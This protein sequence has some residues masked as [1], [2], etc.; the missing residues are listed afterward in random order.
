MGI[1]GLT[2]VSIGGLG[3]SGATLAYL[4]AR[5]GFRVEAFDVA[6]GYRKACG[7]A[8]TL[9]PF[10]E[11]I[12]RAT[13]S[14]VTL[15]TR[16][17][18]AVNGEVVQDLSLKPPPWAIVDKALLVS[19][20]REMAEAEGAELKAGSWPGPVGG[21]LSVDA[22]GPL[23]DTVKDAVFLYRVYSKAEWE[24]DTVYLDFNV[25]DRGVYWV[26]PA[27]GEGRLVNIGAGFEGVWSGRE[28]EMR[29][30]RLHKTL[31]GSTLEPVDRRG[32]P[33]QL[34]APLRLYHEGVFKVGEAGGFLLRTGGEG[35]RPGMLSALHLARAI[36]SAGL[37]DESKILA[38]YR[39]YSAGLAD[40]VR[41]SKILLSIVRG[42]SIREA[43]R[44]LKSL[45]PSFWERFVRAQVTSTYLIR[46]L[47]HPSVAFGVARALLSY[48]ASRA[49]PQA[50]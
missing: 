31:L 15:V 49:P 27:D 13:R 10:T 47:T 24:P 50:S 44:L 4:L 19:R 41:V 6:R 7:D 23:A 29:I 26:F 28:V 43:S 8:L 21:R 40:E 9:K 11:E 5:E 42:S 30:A 45:P 17:I 12:A 34:F 38:Y 1:E 2:A 32:A 22:R 33:M 35:N 25:R 16:Y 18:I 37:E 46:L 48:S 14:V 3:V 20:L 36:A 39:L